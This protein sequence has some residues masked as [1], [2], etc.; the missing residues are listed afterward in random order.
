[1]LIRMGIGLREMPFALEVGRL[2]L[3]VLTPLPLPTDSFIVSSFIC[4]WRRVTDDQGVLDSELRPDLTVEQA[5][6]LGRRAILAAAHR[7]AYSGGSI[8]CIPPS[9]P[10]LFFIIFWS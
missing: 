3:M 4:F 5:V 6:A 8:N 1:M 9:S 2:L 7:D 10:L